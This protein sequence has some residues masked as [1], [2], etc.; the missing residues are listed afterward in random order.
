MKNIALLLAISILPLSSAFAETSPKQAEKG[1]LI[2]DITFKTGS[3]D[4]VKIREM[5]KDK[6]TV[7]IFYRGGWCPF[8]SRQLMDLNGI[9][10]DLEDAGFQILAVSADQPSKIAA[11]PG[12][13]KLHYTLLSDSTMAG[14]TAMG[15]AFVVADDVVAKYK[16]SRK[17]DLEIASGETHH[18]LPH[19]AVFIID[20]KGIIQ[21]AHVDSNYKKRLDSAKVLK[22]VEKIK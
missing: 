16:A 7:L 10:D 12:Y 17:N 21:F 8:C 2:P 20:T 19:P 6:P 18:K 13:K 15:I 22:E 14:A 3:G 4:D 9:Q 1:D 5:V 11:T